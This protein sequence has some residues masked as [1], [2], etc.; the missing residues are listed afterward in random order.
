MKNPI[1]SSYSK[2]EYSLFEKKILSEIFKSIK[3][4]SRFSIDKLLGEED[5]LN[6]YAHD[7]SY[8]YMKAAQSLREKS[9]IFNQAKQMS[10]FIDWANLHKGF[11]QVQISSLIVP[12]LIDFC[13]SNP[14]M[15]PKSLTTLMTF[16]S[17]YS[18]TFYTLFKSIVEST[19]ENDFSQKFT[20]EELR[21]LL[22]VGNKYQSYGAFKQ[23]ILLACQKELKDLYI[24]G[25]NDITFNLIEICS[26][27]R[28]VEV[29]KFHF[30]IN[31][32]DTYSQ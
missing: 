28:K 7:Q 14:T 9:F 5:F 11:L 25:E 24:K 10:G 32:I 20:L 6:I 8:E 1:C 12:L 29:L 27:A 26:K 15:G 30:E 23:K 13:K 3:N 22:E 19:K 18:M 21:S 4:R 17:T 2:Y 16:K 31:K